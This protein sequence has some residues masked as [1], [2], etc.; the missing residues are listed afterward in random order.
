MGAFCFFFSLL[1]STVIFILPSFYISLIVYHSKENFLFAMVNDK[2]N[3]E[4]RYEMKAANQ[5]ITKTRKQT[6]FSLQERQTR[7]QLALS[8]ELSQ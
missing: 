8:V 5:G 6:V 3:V 2:K 1:P 7:D 4:E